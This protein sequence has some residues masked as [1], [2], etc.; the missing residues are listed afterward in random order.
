MATEHD[1]HPGG[2]V[3]IKRCMDK[4][5]M[6]RHCMDQRC[7]DRGRPGCFVRQPV[8]FSVFQFLWFYALCAARYIFT[9]CYLCTRKAS[10]TDTQQLRVS[11]I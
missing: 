9:Q 1:E 7:M 5:S 8:A 3:C 11:R 2:S 4:R 6:D 10:V